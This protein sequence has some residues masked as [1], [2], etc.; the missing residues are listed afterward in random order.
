MTQT[1]NDSGPVRTGPPE[2]FDTIA[3]L[4]RHLD[5]HR[6]RGAQIG[7]VPTMG[8]LHDGHA[9]LMRAAASD[10]DVV[11]ASVFVN[12]LQFGANEDL[13]SYPR[14]LARDTQVA[15]A[16]GVTVLFAPTVE[17]MYPNGAVL[18]SVSVAELSTRWD[19]A[20]RPTHFAGMATVVA[21]LFNI[22]GRCHA[23]FGEKDYQQLMIIKRMVADLSIPVT[24]VGCPIVR[25]ADGLAM[26][27]RNIHL[28]PPEREAATVLRRALDEA[29]RLIA[30]GERSPAIIDRAMGAI[31]ANEPRA[32][33]D[34]AATIDASTLAPAETADHDSHLIIA[35]RVGATRLIDNAAGTV[36]G[37]RPQPMGTP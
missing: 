13:S 18:T 6:A 4:R 25:E 9:S 37:H 35:A 19:G 1:D 16:N 11:V 15:A 20:A 7:F 8:Y 14:D 5:D 36:S 27:S 34:Y 32:E 12:P 24:V 17:E 3:G 21:K 28:S 26:S 33:L 30:D 23:Y 2:T 31:V 10:N 29:Q 22:A